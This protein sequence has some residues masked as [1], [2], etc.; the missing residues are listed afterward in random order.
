MSH[1]R[2]HHPIPLCPDLLHIILDDLDTQ[3]IINLLTLY[4]DLVENYPYYL[5]FYDKQQHQA[6]ACHLF[7]WVENRPSNIARVDLEQEARERK[8]PILTVKEWDKTMSTFGLYGIKNKNLD[9][10]SHTD[11]TSELKPEHKI[12]L[13][14]VFAKHYIDTT[15]YDDKYKTIPLLRLQKTKE[16]GYDTRIYYDEDHPIYILASDGL[17]YVSH[18]GSKNYSYR[19]PVKHLVTD[20]KD[21]LKKLWKGLS[22]NENPSDRMGQLISNDEQKIITSITGHVSYDKPLLVDEED[23][24]LLKSIEETKI[25]IVNKY[26]ITLLGL[27][28][29]L[30]IGHEAFDSS[31]PKSTLAYID[32]FHRFNGQCLDTRILGYRNATRKNSARSETVTP[33][34]PLSLAIVDLLNYVFGLDRGMFTILFTG[35]A[36]AFIKSFLNQNIIMNEFYEAAEYLCQRDCFMIQQRSNITLFE[37]KKLSRAQDQNILESKVDICPTSESS[38]SVTFF[39]SNNTSSKPVVS[40]NVKFSNERK[41]G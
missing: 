10:W 27:I 9:I 41:H 26:D 28:D 24:K 16:E 1:N 22:G 36:I 32:D 30:K 31:I 34:L 23:S 15:R 6:A 7:L 35:I 25:S 20:Q 12:L 29:V 14:N 37:Q 19:S 38:S 8:I 40:E 39:S 13:D 5:R 21:R 11:I 4:S 2:Q 33:Q 17:F 18:F 3:T